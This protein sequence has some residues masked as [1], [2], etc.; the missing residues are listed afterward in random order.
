MDSKEIK[1]RLLEGD[2]IEKLLESLECE[3]IK[4]EQRGRLVTA[5]LP[6][7]FNSTNR[8]AVQVYAEEGMFVKIRNMSD[9]SGDIFS[10]VSFLEFKSEMNDLQS[11]FRE[12]LFY[13]ADLFGWNT[14]N[15]RSKRKKDYVAPL[16]ALASKSRKSSI[17][18]PNEPISESV[19]DNFKK[20][21]IMDGIKKE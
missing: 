19:L 20:S 1:K 18:V 5:Q 10:L 8:R 14:S 12:S 4:R 21:L 3:H 7:R 17:R 9:F 16:K 2:N 11:T 15:V 6:M 13:I